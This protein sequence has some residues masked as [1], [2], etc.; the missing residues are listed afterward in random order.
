MGLVEAAESGDRRAALE[1]LRDRLATAIVGA[2]ASKLAPLANQL[3]AVLADLDGLPV[4]KGA[5][6]VD[7]LASRRTD[8]RSKSQVGDVPA[9]GDVVG[10]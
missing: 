5:S 7:D 8:R 10:H 2:S 4:A 6:V 9:G 3:R 1:A